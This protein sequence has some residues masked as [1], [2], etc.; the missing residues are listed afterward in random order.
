[1]AVFQVACG[2]QHTEGETLM[3][4]CFSLCLILETLVTVQYESRE[5]GPERKQ[6]RKNG[7]GILLS[8]FLG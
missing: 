7:Q 4:S 5:G 2:L 1:M 8:S 3:F 6:G